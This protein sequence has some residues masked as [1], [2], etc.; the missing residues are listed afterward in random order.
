MGPE[1]WPR[2]DLP[3]IP[4]LLYLPK[5][6]ATEVGGIPRGLKS[7]GPATRTVVCTKNYTDGSLRQ[8]GPRIS[9]CLT[10][11]INMEKETPGAQRHLEDAGEDKIR[12]GGPGGGEVAM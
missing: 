7:T 2:A 3:E 8:A 6:V 12:R 11:T 5:Y 10:S 9:R 4:R 1:L